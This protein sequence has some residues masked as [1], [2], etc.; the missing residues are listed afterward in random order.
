[1]WVTLVNFDLWAHEKLKLYWLKLRH[2]LWS[3]LNIMSKSQG[4]QQSSKVQTTVCAQNILTNKAFNQSSIKNH[5]HEIVNTS[6]I[7]QNSTCPS[8]PGCF[9]IMPP[10]DTA[11]TICP[12]MSTHTA[13]TVSNKLSLCD[14]SSPSWQSELS[15]AVCDVLGLAVGLDSSHVDS[16]LDGLWSW[17]TS[18]ELL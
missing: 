10:L 12:S 11:L 9:R 5:T 1:M 14:S 15:S 6:K 4:Y 13:P 16:L 8:L 18:H 17:E 3:C 2:Y 7:W